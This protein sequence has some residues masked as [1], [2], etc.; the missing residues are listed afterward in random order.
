MDSQIVSQLAEEFKIDSNEDWIETTELNCATP[1][2]GAAVKIF[3]DGFTEL[4]T[5]EDEDDNEMT[6]ETGSEQEE[7]SMEGN[8]KHFRLI[9]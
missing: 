9:V 8:R 3:D 4:D 6:E 5:L 1:S 7:E 2:S